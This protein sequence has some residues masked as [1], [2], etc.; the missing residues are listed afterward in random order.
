VSVAPELD[1]LW[2]PLLRTLAYIAPGPWLLWPT[3]PR[4]GYA[5]A[6][7]HVD[8][9]LF[10][11][12]AHRRADPLD[13]D[14]LLNVLVRSGLSDN[15]VR[16]QLLTMLI[17]G[18]DTATAALAWA[19]HV[20]SQFTEV[21][22][23][24]R[25]EVAAV[26]GNQAPKID[27]LP[28]LA[29]VE[30]VIKETLRLYPPIHVGNRR[31]ACDLAFAGWRIPA[32]TRVLFSIFLT[33]RDPRYWPEPER[34]DPERFNPQCHTPPAAFAYLPFGGGPRFCIGAAM[35]QVEVKAVLARLLQRFDFQPLSKTVH[36]RMG[37]TLEPGKLR[38]RIRRC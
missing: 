24:A 33:H 22:T 10:R 26:L 23:R 31:A 3:L 7:R 9:Y 2:R 34:F 1:G 35:A 15:M 16:D 4:P 27:H 18:H 6:L 13:G 11:L 28:Q 14:D 19:L 30:R 8:H 5:R 29:Y 36:L 21:Q 25:T 12:I 32:G 37:A 17:A 20:L 38:L